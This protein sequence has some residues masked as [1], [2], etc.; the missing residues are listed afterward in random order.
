MSFKKM[1]AKVLVLAFLEVGALAGVPMSQTK[2]VHV[3]K[4]D[5]PPR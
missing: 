1:L 2:I 3:V 5:D 4:K